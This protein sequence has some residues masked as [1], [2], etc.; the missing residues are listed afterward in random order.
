MLQF[1]GWT[2]A[3]N[4]FAVGE[5]LWEVDIVINY[6]ANLCSRSSFIYIVGYSGGFDLVRIKKFK[7]T[8]S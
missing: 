3:K 6:A 8:I 5:F 4:K 1:V 2:I 7:Q